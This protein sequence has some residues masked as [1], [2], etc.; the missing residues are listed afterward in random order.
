[1]TLGKAV[2]LA[3]DRA[4]EGGHKLREWV[5]GSKC[6]GVFWSTSCRTCGAMAMAEFTES[7][8]VVRSGS[9]QTMTCASVQRKK[10]R[11]KERRRER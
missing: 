10:E 5:I 9:T 1:M 11:A 7:G 4:K 2:D 8:V 6:T 3:D